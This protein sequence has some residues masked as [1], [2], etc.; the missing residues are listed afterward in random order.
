MK[1]PSIQSCQQN[2]FEMEAIAPLP[3]HQQQANRKSEDS[4]V[5]DLVDALQ[6][7]VLTFSMS[8]AD[9][10]PKRLID[11][12]PMA[13]MIALM[14]GEELAT[15]TEVVIYIYTRTLEA[16][17][18]SEWV[19]IYTYV[20]CTTLQQYFNEDHWKEVGAPVKLSD[21]LEFK[22]RDLRSHIY[23]KRRDI[24]KMSNREQV[25]I[26]VQLPKKET[27]QKPAQEQQSLFS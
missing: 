7:P 9:T 22:L 20:S 27:K 14:K 2:L 3:K 24:L 16:P 18:D 11:I 12:L 8:W 4:T 10:I 6:A 13:R 21:W 1:R 17:M 5:F 23:H 26:D 19:D 25:P 15:Y